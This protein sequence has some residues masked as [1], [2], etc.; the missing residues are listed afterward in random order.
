MTWGLTEPFTT[1]IMTSAFLAGTIM[2]GCSS[3]PEPQP[4]PS[5]QEI[6]QDSDRFFHKMDQEEGKNS[7]S[8]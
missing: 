1:G 8:P 7:P 6:R 4:A 2:M 3:T 5:K